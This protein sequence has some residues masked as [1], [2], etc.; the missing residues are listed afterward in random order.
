MTGETRRQRAER[1]AVLAR[2]RAGFD[3]IFAEMK[4]GRPKAAPSVLAWAFLD[5]PVGLNH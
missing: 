4:E 3:A 1:E 5:L 2:L